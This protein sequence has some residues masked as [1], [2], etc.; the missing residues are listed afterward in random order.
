M[1]IYVQV[2]YM[3]SVAQEHG[4]VKMYNMLQTEKL[5]TKNV[6]FR[7]KNTRW[8]VTLKVKI[9]DSTRLEKHSLTQ[10]GIRE[11]CDKEKHNLITLLLWSLYFFH[12]CSVNK[13][14]IQK[15]APRENKCLIPQKGEVH[16]YRNRM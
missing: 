12:R 13:Y 5:Y 1:Y 3:Y 9:I 15:R 14:S 7:Q 16:K 11:S 6:G 8:K 10:Q 4:Q 2:K